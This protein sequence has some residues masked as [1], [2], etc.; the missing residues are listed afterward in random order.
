MHG[1]N[2]RRSLRTSAPNRPRA[3]PRPNTEPKTATSPR[4]SQKAK[5]GTKLLA[6]SLRPT[7]HIHTW[8]HDENRRHQSHK[9]PSRRPP[10]RAKPAATR[11]LKPQMSKLCHESPSTRLAVSRYTTYPM[12]RPTGYKTAVP[13]P[14]K[15]YNYINTAISQNQ[16]P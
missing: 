4:R 1:P 13:E 12:E 10:R 16:S 3:T 2:P 6:P 5:M 8:V 15:G 7:P 9:R 14:T 11:L